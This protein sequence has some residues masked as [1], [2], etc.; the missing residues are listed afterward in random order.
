MEY[1]MSSVLRSFLVLGFILAFGGQAN[2]NPPQPVHGAFMGPQKQIV[3]T[4]ETVEKVVQ[5]LPKLIALTKNYKGPHSAEASTKPVKNEKYEAL[6]AALS[7]LSGEHGFKDTAT[8]QRTVET[9]MLTAGFLKSGKTLKQ[10]DAQITA[11][12]KQIETNPKLS[13]KQK[14]SLLRRMHIQISMVVPTS[15]NIKTVQPFFPRIIAITSKQ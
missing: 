9:T 1:N 10:V 5:V 7:S 2:A 14:S 6:T 4:K 15:E 11:T 12:Q 3:L 13:E 8:M